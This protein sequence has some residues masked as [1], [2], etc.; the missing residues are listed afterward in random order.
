MM[1]IEQVNSL[2]DLASEFGEIAEHAPW[3]AKAAGN[4]RPFSDRAMM[5][6]SFQNVIMTADA[7]AQLALIRAH[8]DLAGKAKLTQDSQ[9]EQKGAGLDNLSQQELQRFTKLNDA[10]KD[11]FGFPFI[12][13]VKGA[14]KFDILQ[15]FEDR[16]GNDKDSEFATAL[17]MVCQ[18]VLFR[19]EDKVS[20]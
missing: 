3:V 15:S 5:I 6:K 16:I 13:A 14:D 1:T 11:R 9:A 7:D 2:P 12:F 19:L 18:I 4:A 17:S 10:Y 8:P 20:S